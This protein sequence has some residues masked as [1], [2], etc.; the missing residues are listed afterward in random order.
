MTN[1]GWCFVVCW[2]VYEAHLQEVGL[3]YMIHVQMLNLAL[4]DVKYTNKHI[5][6]TLIDFRKEDVKHPLTNFLECWNRARA[7]APPKNRNFLDRTKN[8]CMLARFQKNSLLLHSWRPPTHKTP[9]WVHFI[10]KVPNPIYMFTCIEWMSNWLGFIV[11]VKLPIKHVINLKIKNITKTLFA[12]RLYFLRLTIS[13]GLCHSKMELKLVM[14]LLLIYYYIIVLLHTI[15]VNIF[16]FHKVL[17]NLG[18]ELS[19]NI[20]TIVDSRWIM[21]RILFASSLLKDET[22]VRL[23]TVT[24]SECKTFK[25]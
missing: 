7:A 12:L 17:I 21:L 9:Y 1:Y 13:K 5:D 4:K 22:F 3:K 24:H 16:Y 10:L 18:E 6:S 20:H 25:K 14:Y 19:L 8:C 23:Y 15:V 11:K 2:N